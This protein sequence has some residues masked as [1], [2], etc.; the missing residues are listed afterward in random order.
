MCLSAFKIPTDITE[1]LEGN[2]FCFIGSCMPTYK[3][4]SNIKGKLCK[5]S[6]TESEV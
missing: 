5:I 3:N 2:K 4:K 1:Y 6:D